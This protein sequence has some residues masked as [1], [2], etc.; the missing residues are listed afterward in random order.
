MDGIE[1]DV[2][3]IGVVLRAN[4]HDAVG[5]Q[6]VQRYGVTVVPTFVL[7]RSGQE[8]WR[9]EGVPNRADLVARIREASK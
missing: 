6:L 8:V 2:R 1:R 7:L 5:R 3:G 4:F 9:L